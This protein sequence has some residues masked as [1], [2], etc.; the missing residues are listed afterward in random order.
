MRFDILWKAQNATNEQVTLR[1]ELRGVGAHALPTV[2]TLE[3]NLMA[4]T[5]RHW[6]SLEIAGTDYQ[7]LGSLVAWRV[8]LWDGNTMLSEQKSFLW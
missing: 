3:T 5:A 2:A 7:N 4:R 8:T 6:T 1:A